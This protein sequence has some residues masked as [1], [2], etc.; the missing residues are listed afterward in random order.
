MKLQRHKTNCQRKSK[1][2]RDPKWATICLWVVV[3]LISSTHLARGQES[4]QAVDSKEVELLQ[5]NDIEFASLDGA[6]QILPATRHSGAD[7]TVA[8]QSSTSPMTSSASYTELQG[9]EIL[10]DRILRRSESPYLAREDLEVLR[11]ARL[12]IEPGVTIEFAPTKGLK[13]SGVLQAVV[14]R[15]NPMGKIHYG[16]EKA[17][18]NLSMIDR[19]KPYI[20]CVHC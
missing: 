20:E 15:K 11:G 19:V 4:P 14:S 12:T 9:G 7:V 6:T 10:S 17:L 16:A 3:T 1:P 18:R 5:D 8:P 13:I 2:H